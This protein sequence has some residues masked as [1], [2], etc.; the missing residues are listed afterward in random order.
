MW[1]MID[2]YQ[3]HLQEH[4]LICIFMS[5]YQYMLEMYNKT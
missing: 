5:E 2:S 3:F 1:C 4:Y